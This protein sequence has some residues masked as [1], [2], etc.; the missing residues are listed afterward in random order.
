[1]T[2]LLIK[3]FIKNPDAVQNAKVR[4]AYG[5]LA[6]CVGI[7]ANMLLSASKFFIGILSG[8]IAVQADAVN[9]LSD[10]GS[11]VVT[12]VGFRM[13][14]KPADKEHPYGHGRMEYV[15]AMVIAFL[16][17]VVG[18][19]LGKE[20]FLKILNP[21]P[22]E[23]NVMSMAVLALSIVAKLWMGL[24]TAGIGKR[25]R[26]SAMTAATKDSLFDMISTSAILISS[27]I[28]YFFKVNLDGYIGVVVAGF[29]LYSGAGIL[30]DAAS[31]LMGEVPPPE[32][33]KELIERL[34]GYD[35]IMDL[36]DLLV[37]SYGPGRTI[38]SVHAEVR[39]DCNFLAIHE[40]IDR[41]ER[42]IGKAMGMMLT[43]HMDP[44]ETDNQVLDSAREKIREIIAAVDEKIMFHDF[45]MV[46]GEKQN[47]LLFDIVLPAGTPVTEQERILSRIGEG[48]RLADPTYCCIIEVDFDYSGRI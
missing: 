42:E 15:T 37:H 43:I 9:N 7:I 35:G 29:V 18:F 20:S 25:I 6:G 46:P 14:A 33:V 13:A 21:T 34:L 16:I 48:A 19:E 12:L 11:N 2:K 39:A 32:L 1:M 5:V 23:F 3:L 10:I 31:P 40:T 36:H 30:R 28:A 41:A 38:A 26:S 17:L 8:S 22:V 4:K 44:V 45:R 27:M 47:N 24:F